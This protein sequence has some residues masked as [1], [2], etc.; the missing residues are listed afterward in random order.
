[1]TSMILTPVATLLDLFAQ[2]CDETATIAE[3]RQMIDDRDSWGKAYALF[4][5]ISQKTLQAERYADVGQYQYLFEEV[6]A[7]TLYN[8]S[9]EPASFDADPPYGIVPNA[10][11]LARRLKIDRS[12]IIEIVVRH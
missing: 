7:K 3:L 12:R 4:Q 6:T 10:L 9:H 8:L 5:K 1:M 11:N 2:H